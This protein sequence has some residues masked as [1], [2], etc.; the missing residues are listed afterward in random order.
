MPRISCRQFMLKSIEDSPQFTFLPRAC[1]SISIEGQN[2]D[3]KVGSQNGDRAYTFHV[4]SL[5]H[6]LNACE[7]R[8]LIGLSTG[9]RKAVWWTQINWLDR[10]SRLARLQVKHRAYHV[11]NLSHKQFLIVFSIKTAPV[12]STSCNCSKSY[13]L[14][15]FGST[16][17]SVPS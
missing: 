5:V 15:L 13:W 16:F 12:P 1:I 3:C 11:P 14:D 2:S 10:S 17:D 7:A 8:R 9:H 4:P 6:K